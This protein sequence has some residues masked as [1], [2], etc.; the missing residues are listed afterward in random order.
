M[1]DLIARLQ[2]WATKVHGLKSEYRGTLLDAL[3]TAADMVDEAADALSAAEARLVSVEQQLVAKDKEMVSRLADLLCT[4]PTGAPFQSVLKRA[5]V[6]EAKVVS[7]ERELKEALGTV[8]REQ[9]E[10]FRREYEI[11]MP[12]EPEWV[13]EE[14]RILMAICNVAVCALG[15]E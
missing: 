11:R 14:N 2:L 10:E 12:Q 15:K 8:T 6:A 13:T 4:V 3:G 9:V 5:E 1:N 7:V